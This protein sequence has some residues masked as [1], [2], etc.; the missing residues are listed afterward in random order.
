MAVLPVKENATY[1]G[2]VQS[3]FTRVIVKMP[4]WGEAPLIAPGSVA[5]IVTVDWQGTLATIPG[6]A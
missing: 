3:P 5:L 6:L 1:S 2:L 4:S